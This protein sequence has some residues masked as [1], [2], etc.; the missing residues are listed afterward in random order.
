[1]AR[2]P[3]E[4]EILGPDDDHEYNNPT[5]SSKEFML[6]VMRDRRV[7]LSARLD[8]AAKV[9][10]YEHPRL[11]QV[12]QD[13]TSGITIRIEGGLPP[14]PGTNVIMPVTDATPGTPP[15]TLH[16]PGK[17]GNGSGA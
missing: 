6:A 2:T 10:A 5:L 12:S 11:A 14:L 16:S 3:I 15:V 1:M 9:S 8:A 7:P 17:K 4:P 13:V